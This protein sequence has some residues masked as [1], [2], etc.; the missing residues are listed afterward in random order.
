MTSSRWPLGFVAFTLTSICTSVQAQIIPDA[1]LPINST[2]TQQENRFQ[3]DGGTPA[4]THLFHSFREFSLPT[5]TEAFFNNSTEIVNIIT[6]VTGGRV[7]NLDGLIRA[8]GIA[9]L[10]LINPNGIIFGP[11]ARL[12]IGGS[13]L[14]STAESLLF[15]DGSEFSATNPQAP[16]LLTIN[17][18]IGLQSGSNPGAIIN[19]SNAI[20]SNG[21]VIGLQVQPH[22]TLA[23]MGGAINFLAGVLTAPQGQIQLGSVGSNEQISLT[24]ASTGFAFAYP[25]VRNFNDINL[26]QQSKIDTSGVGGGAISLRGRQISL[27]D[28]SVI[29][30]TTWGNEPGNNILIEAERL[31]VQNGSSI[32]T[33]TF[34]AAS[35]GD[36]TVNTSE[37]IELIGTD[38]IVNIILSLFSK[39][40]IPILPKD[41][42]LT[43]SFGSGQGGD[44]T[45]TTETLTA[46]N[47]GL[48]FTAAFADG[49]GGNLILNAKDVN[50]INAGLMAGTANLG[51][52]GNITL[53]T[54]TLRMRDSSVIVTVTLD[55]G[56]AGN[57]TVNA[58]DAI[59]ML[60]PLE[61][62]ETKYLAQ[63]S[64]GV[65][66]TALTSEAYGN[67]DAGDL[68]VNT[69]QLTLNNLAYITAST[70]GTGQAGNLTVNAEQLQLSN[71]G[72]IESATM[73]FNSGGN[74]IINVSDTVEM[75]SY[76]TKQGNS[77]SIITVSTRGASAAGDLTL[78]TRRLMIRD[79]GR[80]SAI[81]FDSGNGGNI[82]INASE[83]IEIIGFTPE[84]SDASG[85]FASVQPST[86]QNLGNGGNIQVK[87]GQLTLENQAIITASGQGKGNAGNIDIQADAISLSNSQIRGIT[88]AGERGNINL[89]SPQIQLRQG[90]S[91]STNS[92]NR[93]GGNITINT[94]NLVG[95]ENSD[96]TANAVQ[97]NGGRVVI[98]AQG[99][100]GTNYRQQENPNTSDITATS[101]LGAEF[102][103]TV[104]LNIP[105]V[106]PTSGL[107]DLQ[108]GFV[109]A[110]TLIDQRCHPGNPQRSSFIITGSGGLPLNPT[111]DPLS[112]DQ[113]WVD[114]RFS[115]QQI[116]PNSQVKS[117]EIVEAQG[118]IIHENGTIELVAET[119][120][121]RPNSSSIPT[122]SC[123]EL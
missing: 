63:Q 92:S 52:A 119:T 30:S 26:S 91:I 99:I 54:Q 79:G 105:I 62:P 61:L 40:D 25:G 18:P 50:I 33:A 55:E 13:F 35:G 31:R 101:D 10:F 73:G 27:T 15:N 94:E 117:K 122:P 59:E 90:S 87:T 65:G 83:S 51:T 45:L 88:A 2:V 123:P 60:G 53:N 98:N 20:D 22:Q 102:N 43:A 5:G 89:Q 110:E 4:G 109:N 41:G 16:P 19:Q 6:R 49:M 80:I 116:Y 93:N 1:T 7:S 38:N 70:I 39:P 11:N 29:T 115:D 69:R 24:Q 37:S 46:L 3:I 76:P 86:N 72:A 121:S 113:G 28:N 85:I 77:N 97:G 56:D 111:T 67:G 78:N 120:N 9:N 104:E 96:I 48:A 112:S 12:E 8:N 44:I 74:L 95:L 14:G 42:L 107:V 68:T 82:D 66:A 118:W 34:G 21:Y 32:S 100:F 64:I 84:E 103:G 106:D 36:L 47:G 17:V 57:L 71:G 75:G 114:H 81:T 108:E 23:L 58:T